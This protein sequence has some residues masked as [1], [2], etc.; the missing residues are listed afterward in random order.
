MKRRLFNSTLGC[1]AIGVWSTAAQ[2]QG[3]P[4]EGKHYLRLKEPAPVSAPAG[5]V[6][7][8]EFFWY[9]CPACNALEP[10][11]EPWTKRL[12]PDVSFRRVPVAFGAV[13]E[14]HQ[15]LFYTLDAMGQLEALHARV[16][17]AI[18]NG[19]QRLDKEADQVAFVRAQ[20]V[21]PAK[22]AETA[23]SFS[24]QTRMRQAKQLAQAYQIEGVPT[25]GVQGRFVTSVA[26]AGDAA[27]ALAVVDYLVAQVRRG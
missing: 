7:V 9:G 3:G 2:S 23:K 17:A 4:I 21:D 18:H 5:K 12:K 15:R 6:D 8:V 24:V 10:A 1:A 25:L 11:L 19:Q 27:R 20:G 26:M 22:F 16:F 13:H 14:S